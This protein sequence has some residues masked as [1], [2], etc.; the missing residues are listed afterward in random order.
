MPEWLKL[1]LDSLVYLGKKCVPKR[2]KPGPDV[3]R[4]E[5]KRPTDA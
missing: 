1:V 2:K 3:P 5:E 4:F